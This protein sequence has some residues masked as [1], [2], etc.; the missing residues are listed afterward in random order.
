MTRRFPQLRTAFLE[1]GASFGV[2]LLGDLVEHWEKRNL[3]A[4]EHTNP[5]NLDHAAL[6]EFVEQYGP[7]DMPALFP[8]TE[9]TEAVIQSGTE[10]ALDEFAACQIQEKGDIRDLFVD[11]I[12]F[13][14]EADDYTNSWAFSDRATPFGA[15]LNAI[16]GSDLGHF[17]VID[18]RQVLPEA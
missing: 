3:D 1:C 9:V 17:D 13:G 18:M 8:R 14:S 6:L 5:A 10:A 2:Q 7:S 15:K 16:F 11:R 12:F 4:L